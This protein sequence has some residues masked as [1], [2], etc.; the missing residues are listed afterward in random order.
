MA[1]ISI[2]SLNFKDL[3]L[4][5]SFFDGLP[6]TNTNSEEE[7]KTEIK[8]LSEP[9]ISPSLYNYLTKIKEEID[10]Y[11][12]HWDYYK[13]ITNPHEYIHTHIF[14]KNY[15]VC[16]Y[17][18]LSRAFF[19]MIEIINIFNFLDEKYEI[20]CFHLA[21]GPGGFIEA[22]N[23][24]RENKQDNYYGMTL[25]S[26]DVNI[27]SW[28]K[29]QTFLNNNKN[30]FIENG[31]S[32]NGD[33]FLESN[34]IYINEKYGSSMEYITGDGGIDFSVDFNNQEDMSLKLIFAQIVYAIIMQKKNGH[35]ILKIFDIFK[36]KTV[37]LLFLLSNLYE[38][39]YIYKPHT[40]RVA[41]S[42]KYIICKYFKANNNNLKNELLRNYKNII[43]N[44]ENIKSLFNKTF[45]NM[46]IN[47]IK[48]IN[49]IYGQQQI[50][51]IN[52]TL[53]LIR[54]YLNLEN[55]DFHNNELTNKN[56]NFELN[57][58]KTNYEL[59]DEEKNESIENKIT[60]KTRILSSE[61]ININNNINP[62]NK[63]IDD[64]IYC[65][66]PPSNIHVFENNTKNDSKLTNVLNYNINININ[67]DFKLTEKNII[68][69]IHDI[70]NN[71]IIKL[72]I[73]KFNNKINVLKNLNIQKSVHW[74]NKYNFAINKNFND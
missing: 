50:E 25:I 11:E 28:K 62:K 71:K 63:E 66:S 56:N 55:L 18:P 36:F 43:G 32:K 42:E 24:V 40:S 41:N 19:K 3:S 1:Y 73:E 58:D 4:D 9:F 38:N 70:S 60:K 72:N 13:K 7:S 26:S 48:E 52:N 12:E 29:S 67:D 30:V 2:P 15:S 47:K 8:Y 49:A 64:E 20:N 53:N 10:I 14:G 31:K 65:Y 6:K 59:S 16:K 51:N 69:N 74:C 33:L 35:F 57:F 44:I 37:E 45:P 23:Y 39:I 17:K 5:I 54:E 46:F 27:P 34:L 68:N 22:F 21:E 61:P